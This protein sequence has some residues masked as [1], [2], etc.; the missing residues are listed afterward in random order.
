MRHNTRFQRQKRTLVVLALVNVALLLGTGF[1]SSS[2]RAA[3]NTQLREAVATGDPQEIRRALVAGADPNIDINEEQ[4]WAG[5]V[6]RLL[7]GRATGYVQPA[8][9]YV[10][11]PVYSTKDTGN[12][13]AAEFLLTFGADANAA[14]GDKHTALHVAALHGNEG[15]ARRLLGRRARKDIV[16]RQHGTTPYEHAVSRGHRAVAALLK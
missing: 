8:L 7:G 5:P 2:R 3:L 10:A 13:L 11:K 12:T 16:C 4:S 1:I 15:L 6:R 14:D 9:V